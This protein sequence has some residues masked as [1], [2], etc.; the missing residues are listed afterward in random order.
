MTRL[1]SDRRFWIIVVLL[2]VIL[3]ALGVYVVLAPATT[4]VYSNI[5]NCDAQW[6]DGNGGVQLGPCPGAPGFDSFATQ[7]GPYVDATQTAQAHVQK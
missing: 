5:I 1:R 6:P 2:V 4:T 7:Y 3:L